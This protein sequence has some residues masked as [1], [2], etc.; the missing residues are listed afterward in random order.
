MQE[1]MG[2][3]TEMEFKEFKELER[4]LLY[5]QLV[6]AYS[7]NEHCRENW[8][9]NW[10]EYDTYFFDNLKYTNSCGFVLVLNGNPIGHISWDPR[11]HPEYVVIG[12]NCIITK[13]KGNGYGHILLLEAINRIKNS[14]KDLKKII[15]TTNEI[16]VAA[17]RNYES[18]GFILKGK[19]KNKDAPFAGDY[20]DYELK[21]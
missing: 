2:E 6:D 7:F 5:H 20:I 13:Y 3:K 12:H 14:Y 1:K 18:V 16:M 19:R 9:N 4:G 11:K 21:L 15:V 10:L 17:Q 8:E